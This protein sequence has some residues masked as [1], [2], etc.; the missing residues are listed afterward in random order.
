MD[1]NYPSDINVTINSTS[2]YSMNEADVDDIDVTNGKLYYYTTSSMPVGYHSFQINCSDG[3]SSNATSWITGP[4]VN[5]FLGTVYP[6][7]G[8]V[9]TPANHSTFFTDPSMVFDWTSTEP[10]FGSLE[11]TW[12][13]SNTSDFAAILDEVTGIPE[14]PSTTSITRSVMYNNGVYYW[15]VR[16]EFSPFVG[17]WYGVTDFTL[18]ENF[19]PPTLTS[20]QVSPSSGNQSQ[21]YNFSV[22][23]TDSDN[24][25]PYSINVSLN[26]VDYEMDKAVPADTNY[27]DGVVYYYTT[28]RDVGTVNY[29]FNCFDGKNLVSSGTGTLD[30][31]YNN[32][33]PPALTGES[34]TPS[35]GNNETVYN[36]TVT[37]TD[38]DNNLPQYINMTL[39]TTVYSLAEANSSDVNAMDGKLYYFNTTIPVHGH[40]EFFMSCWDGGFLNTTATVMQPEVNPFAFTNE[41][42]NVA[43]FQDSYPWST[44]INMQI[45]TSYSISYTIFPSTS[46]TSVDLSSYDKVLIPSVQSATYYDRL[47]TNETRKWLETYVMAG[48]VLEIH[49]ATQGRILDILPFDYGFVYTTYNSETINSSFTGHEIV[50][51]VTDDGLDAWGTSAHNRIANL[52]VDDDVIV[53]DES[54]NFYPRLVVSNKGLGTMILTGLTVEWAAVNNQGDGRQLLENMLVY[55]NSSGHTAAPLSP[56][57][58]ETFFNGEINFTWGDLRYTVDD[59]NYTLQIANT[60]DFFV[61]ADEVN[62]IPKTQ[63]NTSYNILLNY[64]TG[65]YYWRVRPRYHDQIG[66]WS[67][68]FELNIIKNDNAPVF[69][70]GTVTPSTGT[71]STLFDFSVNYTDVNDNP[72]YYVNITINGAEYEMTNKYSDTDYTDSCIFNYSIYLLPGDYDYFFNTTDG[73]FNAST[74]NYTMTVTEGSTTIPDLLNIQF[75]PSSGDNL[76]LFN[77]TVVYKDLDNNLPKFINITIN[78]TLYNMSEAD[79]SD[80]ITNDGKLYFLNTTL[81]TYGD[82]EFYINC[83]DVGFANDS[84]I[85]SGPAVSPFEGTYNFTGVHQVLLYKENDP[86]GGTPIEDVLNSNGITYITR[87]DTS[88]ASIDYYNYQ[89]VIF[90]SYQD[91]WFNDAINDDM[92]DI[93]FYVRNGGIIEVHCAQGSN[94][95]HT[96]PGGVSA[97]RLDTDNLATNATHMFH[98]FMKGVNLEDFTGFSPHSGAY[99]SG[100]NA[101]MDIVAYE[102]DN[103]Y[104]IVVVY[105]YGEGLIILS[106]ISVEYAYV[107]GYTELLENM[108]QYNR[109]T[110]KPLTPAND[111]IAYNGLVN[112]TWR[113]AGAGQGN[114]NYT[115]Q[116]ATDS[117]FT[118][119][120][121]EIMNI[122]DV[123][124]T[125]YYLH[126]LTI[127]DRYYWRVLPYFQGIPWNWTEY[128]YF[129]LQINNFAPTLTLEN[130]DP[131]VGPPGTMFNFTVLYTD[132]DNRTPVLSEVHVWAWEWS[133]LKVNA[134]DDDYTDGVLY[135]YTQSIGNEN[136]YTVVFEFSDGKTTVSTAPFQIQV[137][138]HFMN[139]D[140]PQVS[141]PV[142]FAGDNF[143]FTVDYT[144][145]LNILPDYIN[146]TIN[147]STYSMVESN[148]SDVVTID[149]KQYMYS[150]TSLII[151]GRYYYQINA[152]VDIFS[153]NT[154]VLLGPEVNPYYGQ[155]QITLVSPANGSA[156]YT[157][158][159]DFTW[160]SLDLGFVTTVYTWQL[161]TSATFSDIT[162]QVD[163]IPET[164]TTTTVTELM[165]V[166]PDTYYWRVRAIYQDMTSGWSQV[167]AFDVELND[168]APTLTN[169]QVDPVEGN[170]THVFN[171]TVD[172][173]DAD[174][175]FPSFINV[176]I[177]GVEYKMVESYPIDLNAMDGK[178]YYF[179]STLP[180]GY[181]TFQVNCSDGRFDASSAVVDA[182]YIN[183]FYGY[184]GVA[185]VSPSNGAGDA[186]GNINF[187]WSSLEPPFG[188][189]NY[190]WQIST[191]PSFSSIEMEVNGIP[192]T[193]TTTTAEINASLVTGTYFWRVRP[194]HDLFNGTWSN[195]FSIDLFKN[196]FAPTL[197]SSQVSPQPSN[198][199]QLQNITIVYSDADN[200]APDY[201]NVTLDGTPYEMTQSTPS[202]TNYVD[203]ATFHYTTYVSSGTHNYS[204]QCND[205]LFKGSLGT[206]QFDVQP[207]V[208]APTLSGAAFSPSMGTG[209]TS[210]EF[211]VTYTDSEGN[212]P[213]VVN[214]T[215]NGTTHV[216]IEADVSDQDVTD[217]K[218]Y[219]VSTTLPYGESSFTVQCS[220][221]NYIAIIP[222]TPGPLVDP[223][224]GQPALSLVSPG[225]GANLVR[226]N[227]TFTWNSLELPLG[228]I[229]Y[230]W[231]I[232]DSPD[233][234]A[235]TLETSNISETATTT[236]VVINTST[237][238][239]TYY[240]R[241]IPYYGH[242]S[243]TP[244]NNHSI[245]LYPN[246]FAPSLSGEVVVPQPSNEL[247]LHN[248]TVVYSD[249]DNNAPLYVN[250][251][252]DGMTT[253]EMVKANTSDTDYTDGALYYLGF[254][255]GSGTHDYS[256]ECDDGVFTDSIPDQQFTVQ[257][258]VNVPTLTNLTFTPSIGGNG[259]TFTFRVT[260]TD[261]DDN[262][263]QIVN[264]SINGSTF[265]MSEVNAVDTDVT[266][267]KDYIV[268]LNIYSFGDHSIQANCSD[269]GFSST[270]GPIAGPRVNPL[271]GYGEVVSTLSP[272]YGQIV[273]TSTATFRWNSLEPSF[274]PITY[275][276]QISTTGTFT[277]LAVNR[278]GIPE[279][280]GSTSQDVVFSL[281]G[282]T[283]GDYYW[284]VIPV[285]NGVQGT[286][287]TTQLITVAID[288]NPGG[289]FFEKYGMFII[290]IIGVVGAVIG[291]VSGAIASKKKKAQVTPAQPK[292]TLTESEIQKRLALHGEV[293]K[294]KGAAKGSADLVGPKTAKELEE[295]KQTESEVSAQLDVKTCIVHK[296]P[297]K[298]TNYS[299]PGCSVFYCL[300]CAQSLADKGEMCWSCGRPLELEDSRVKIP[301]NY[302][303]E[304]HKFY[305][306]T[307]AKYHAVEDPDF[308]QWH[309]CP[310]CNEELVYIKEC[311]YCNQPIS[312]T[313]DLYEKFKGK[314]MQCSK[315]QKNVVL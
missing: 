15:R 89:K 80:G 303:K 129:D 275:I 122:P 96:Y 82:Y 43:I 266:D 168:A 241:V 196:D 112:F 94:T 92:G 155:P 50:V 63:G 179:N 215:I 308:E 118:E 219:T 292:K 288:G 113:S 248:V 95:A 154:A 150:T 139:V 297:I 66:N 229:N 10:A 309:K 146:I 33:A 99:F 87:G 210:F 295:L 90:A 12:Q 77:F 211:N 1:N 48:G 133:M 45:L 305:C 279:G 214:I 201:V 152:S 121:T 123:T 189:I 52:T 4:T 49:G 5:P 54:G 296:G 156:E 264:I 231:Q 208:V 47:L 186:A 185:L 240:W 68:Y 86:W 106:G 188:P 244:S 42:E 254:L 138:D 67:Y 51:N 134:S 111:S 274:G 198:E 226:G 78:E 299:C 247:M 91:Y 311:P 20:D 249:P 7:G 175:N 245:E 102:T 27:T 16:P 26:G 93:E 21:L 304:Q 79:S 61:I 312:L 136:N 167:G 147:G 24:N 302:L 88:I 115:L 256:F 173:T 207:N 263:A 235:I 218:I 119:N 294:K 190:T 289:S 74:S 286:P 195:N 22:V 233:F 104:P 57:D 178:E 60:S 144:D 81:D 128:Q 141:P 32:L 166:S 223:F 283:N 135:Y 41:I 313:K 253:Y 287:S 306:F 28:Y 194:Y 164:A 307:C 126:P 137:I 184:P 83:S 38:S 273:Q 36:F 234:S 70:N 260:Y 62:D 225:D 165:N 212:L 171:F 157:W 72:P 284:R 116:I 291:V 232:S 127:E 177:S 183:P 276:F 143:T 277:D 246:E 149:G 180:Y 2:T 31:A 13:L 162:R 280:A 158:D 252:F 148:A 270:I 250:V 224:I 285:Y 124:N 216:M 39:N 153:D 239:N 75:T 69:T 228:A 85:I 243:G 64:S 265:V 160:D 11:F 23:Y 222:A 187:T 191:S 14:T 159:V 203:G 193:I 130:A 18:V 205:T 230:T 237:L 84:G 172:Y 19:A 163:E 117:L 278:T 238:I 55:S 217:G 268:N 142:G 25:Y 242:L 200:N 281:Y 40:Y 3:A 298:G 9:L 76:T 151:F 209:A 227:I 101:S 56:F 169:P 262:L 109:D 282:I 17:D 192:E 293:A 259:T 161:S 204:F 100:L 125:T 176:T 267:G 37:Y 132:A 181:H 114:F 202:D 257:P 221:W 310:D 105:E 182:P 108:I 29:Q 300:K 73:R 97:T 34:V 145:T 140:N 290:I 261:R 30:V 206:Q 269:G 35:I 170:L 53:H 199:Y 131:M 271:I 71:Q 314:L 174:N 258:N 197:S 8:L 315:C 98:P 255:I 58:G 65:T 6:G 59:V 272:T 251:T 236:S 103:G 107:N 120:L 46:F 213:E 110:V 301:V 44:S 220:D